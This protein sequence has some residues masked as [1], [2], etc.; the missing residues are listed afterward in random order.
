MRYLVL[1]SAGALLVSCSETPLEEQSDVERS[2]TDKQVEADAQSLEEAADKAVKVL[3]KEIE[4]ELAEEGMA[5]TSQL[6]TDI[7]ETQTEA[8]Q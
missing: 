3:E 4:A 5:E 8:D 7:E 1:L 6:A 2:E